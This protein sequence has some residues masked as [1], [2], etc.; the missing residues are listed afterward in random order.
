MARA[1]T[2]LGHAEILTGDIA[3]NF[4]SEFR[5]SATFSATFFP[6]LA[7][8]LFLRLFFVIFKRRVTIPNKN[9]HPGY[10]FRYS[11]EI[12]ASISREGERDTV[13]FSWTR[14]RASGNDDS[15]LPCP[16][17]LNRSRVLQEDLPV[18]DRERKEG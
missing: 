2:L 1:T 8:H 18:R 5:F 6:N 16:L 17:A 14:S 15:L 7:A 10:G 11:R 13:G 3:R 12:D 4:R 9:G